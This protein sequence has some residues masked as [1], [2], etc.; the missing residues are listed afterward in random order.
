M[1]GSPSP[2]SEGVRGET[3]SVG[4]RGETPNPEAVSLLLAR[5]SRGGPFTPTKLHGENKE[6]FR[7]KKLEIEIKYFFEKKS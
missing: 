5:K 6:K 3:P 7:K 4:V 1:R 2:P